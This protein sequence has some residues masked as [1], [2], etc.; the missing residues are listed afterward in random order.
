MARLSITAV[1]VDVL[2]E[3]MRLTTRYS[4]GYAP[5]L[6]MNTRC[7]E[8]LVL[9][10]GKA[11]TAPNCCFICDRKEHDVGDRPMLWLALGPSTRI[12]DTPSLVPVNIRIAWN[13]KRIPCISPKQQMCD[14]SSSVPVGSVD[15]STARVS[16]GSFSADA[17]FAVW[18]NAVPCPRN[19]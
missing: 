10:C 9:R 6:G 5:R 14:D 13:E 12:R 18:P 17:T 3:T 8:L 16:P 7:N 11:W 15:V 1:K 19:P 2:L 4:W